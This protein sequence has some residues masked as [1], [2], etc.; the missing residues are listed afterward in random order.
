MPLQPARVD[1]TY[2]GRLRQYK[3][4]LR[5][6]LWAGAGL[7]GLIPLVTSHLADEAPAVLVAVA[8]TVV[9]FGGGALAFARVGFEWEATLLERAIEDADDSDAKRAERL[10]DRF[11]WLDRSTAWPWLAELCYWLELLAVAS[12][13]VIY[14]VAVWWAAVS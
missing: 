8:A 3:V 4:R 6:T 12:A 9:V 10:P 1:D 11:T 13:A 7:L 14:L 5:T 2:G